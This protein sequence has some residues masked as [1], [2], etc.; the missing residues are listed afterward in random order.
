MSN[1]TYRVTAPYITL[2]VHSEE[3]TKLL[4][5]YKDALAPEGVDQDDIERHLRK[6]MVEEVQGAELKA[7]KTQQ[8]EAEK[9]EKAA[10]AA[11]EEAADKPAL[12]AK[13]AGS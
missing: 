8:V 9:A 10:D 6:G 12:K 13:G 4:G 3:G 2:R 7:V 1:K 5:F 11:G